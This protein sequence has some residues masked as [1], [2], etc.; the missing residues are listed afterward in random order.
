MVVNKK[1]EMLKE[2]N[3]AFVKGDWNSVCGHLTEDIE[4]TM[5]GSNKI[6]GISAFEE[7]FQSMILDEPPTVEISQIITHGRSAV[8]EGTIRLKQEDGRVTSYAFCDICQFQ[9][10]KEPKIRK[11]KSFVMK[12]KS[13]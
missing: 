9:S 5:V 6:I 10:F 1:A 12:E 7:A 13:N 11:M 2:F 3:D 4:W 8:V